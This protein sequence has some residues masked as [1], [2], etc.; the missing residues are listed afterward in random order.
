MYLPLDFWESLRDAGALE[1][2]RGG[3]VVD[4]EKVPRYLT[5]TQFINLVQNGWIGSRG[6]ASEL[7]N[8]IVHNGLKERRSQILAVSTRLEPEEPDALLSEHPD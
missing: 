1:G 7:L 2:P 4:P 3:L 5:N 6:A 8:E